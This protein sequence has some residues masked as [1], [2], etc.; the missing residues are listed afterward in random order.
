MVK[1]CLCRLDSCV[2]IV[3][4]IRCNWVCKYSFPHLV[5]SVHAHPVKFCNPAAIKSAAMAD[6]NLT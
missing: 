5:L 3:R 4:G 6:E 1:I 2:R